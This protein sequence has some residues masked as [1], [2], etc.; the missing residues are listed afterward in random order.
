[1]P[2]HDDSEQTTWARSATDALAGV[3]LGP[4]DW[5]SETGS[6]N[7]DLLA[8]ARAG[9]PAGRIRVADHQTAGRGRRDRSWTTAPGDALLVS[10]LVRPRVEPG[11]LAIVT[12]ALAV[13]A[14]EACSALG[15]E[16]VRI[17]WPNDL[18]VGRAGGWR[19]LAGIL[20]QSEQGPS[21]PA[22]VV[23]M[24]LN[25]VGERLGPLT[26]RAIALDALGPVPD[27][28]DLLVGVFERFAALLQDIEAGDDA[29]LR[30]RYRRHSATIGHEVRCRLDSTVG[31]ELVEG[32]ALDVDESGALLVEVAG[33]IRRIITGDVVSVRPAAS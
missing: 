17:K 8:S 31:A 5:V 6:T 29:D 11:R 3:G 30:T 4:V 23:G 22:V 1:M 33:A 16:H 18:V 24:G 26:D 2:L 13:A 10:V 15:H 32:L 27:R 25:L 21:G 9:A 19:K 28:V 20:A 7:A 12:A 14:V